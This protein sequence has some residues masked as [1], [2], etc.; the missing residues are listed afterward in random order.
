MSAR[1]SSTRFRPPR[2]RAGP[3]FVQALR[4]LQAG[5]VLQLTYVRSLPHWDL[6]DRPVSPEVVSLLLGCSEVEPDPDALF[7]G[8]PAQCWR[9]RG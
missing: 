5:K 1:S 4:R 7:P 3:T 6:D 8:A 9:I 2:L